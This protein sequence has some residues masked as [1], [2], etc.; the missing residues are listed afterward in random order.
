MNKKTLLI[1]MLLII[2]I[3]ISMVIKY[4]YYNKNIELLKEDQIDL[5]ISKIKKYKN[6]LILNDSISIF[7]RTYRVYPKKHEH[8]Y[9]NYYKYIESIDDPFHL[10]KK[11]DNDTLIIIKNSDTLFYKLIH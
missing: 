8:F 6:V 10:S 7:K 5:D 9:L 2:G 4:H 11:A 1:L 3:F